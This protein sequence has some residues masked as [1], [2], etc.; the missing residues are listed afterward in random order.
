MIRQDALNWLY[1]ENGGVLDFDGIYGAQCV[2][3]FNFYYRFLTGHNPYSD[4]YGVPGAKD[5]WNVPTDL[6]AKVPNNPNDPNQL[7]QTG[8]ILIYNSSWGGG[9]GHVEMVLSADQNGVNVSAQNSKGQYVDVEFRPWKRIVGGLIGWLSF[10]GF[11][12]EPV[13][14]VPPPP[15]PTPVIINDPLPPVIPEVPNVPTPTP[16]P[17]ETQPTQP[18]TPA[19]TVPPTPQTGTPSPEVQKSFW[20]RLPDGVKRILHTTWQ[21]AIPTLISGLY[22]ARSSAEIKAAFVAAGAVALA[23]LKA[24]LL[25]KSN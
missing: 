13:T 8:D 7:P 22:M 2:D 4:G 15:E 21:V 10:N 5:L 23:A 12:P 11:A 18:E 1:S 9:L 16:T 14:T 19:P 25:G 6:F 20:N 24:I 3:Y 17:V